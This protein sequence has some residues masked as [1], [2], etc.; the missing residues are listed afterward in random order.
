MKHLLYSR[1]TQLYHGLRVYTR[2][3]FQ[4]CFPSLVV[5]VISAAEIALCP[6]SPFHQDFRF[7]L[8][9]K[10]VLHI[11]YTFRY[12]LIDAVCFIFSR[13]EYLFSLDLLYRILNSRRVFLIPCIFRFLSYRITAHL[14]FTYIYLHYYII[15]LFFF[16]FFFRKHI[17]HWQTYRAIVL[18]DK[19][20][21][22][23][24]S[25]CVCGLGTSFAFVRAYDSNTHR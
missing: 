21:L 23:S 24:R 16:P 4:Q 2:T 22:Q 12:N 25:C 14:Q 18:V 19:E 8:P 13:E 6:F 7:D 5:D 20:V 9:P 10:D 1:N 15:F 3:G 11:F 17:T